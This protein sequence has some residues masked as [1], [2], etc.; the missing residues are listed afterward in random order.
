MVLALGA[1]CSH[2]DILWPTSKLMLFSEVVTSDEPGVLVCF[3]GFT[4]HFLG[5]YLFIKVLVKKHVL[6]FTIYMFL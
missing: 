3:G 4:E 5:F 6:L 1:L 2:K